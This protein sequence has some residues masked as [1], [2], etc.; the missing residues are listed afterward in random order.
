MRVLGS[1]I[2]AS[3]KGG[4]DMRIV[5]VL[6]LAAGALGVQVALTNAAAPPNTKI[7]GQIKGPNAKYLSRVSGIRSNGSTWTIIVTG[8]SCSFAKAK[9]PGLLDQWKKAK[10]G[11]ALKLP[12]YGCVKML[13]TGYDGKGTASGGLMCRLGGAPVSIFGQKTFAVRET[14]PYSIAQIKAFFGI[15]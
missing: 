5:L 15:R 13:D 1:I 9:A 12:G 14:A 8:V 4:E 2:R 11:A 10:L 3:P 6:A 7:C